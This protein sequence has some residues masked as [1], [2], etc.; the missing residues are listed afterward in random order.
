MS[1]SHGSIPSGLTLYSFDEDE[2]SDEPR[3]LSLESNLEASREAERRPTCYRATNE[4]SGEI[5]YK[6]AST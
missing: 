4:V 6:R 2:F 5:V 3:T 1:S